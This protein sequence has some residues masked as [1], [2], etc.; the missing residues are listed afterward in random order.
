MRSRTSYGVSQAS[1]MGLAVGV[2]AG[3]A[4]GLLMAP[5]RGSDMRARL[6]DRA[7]DGS[8]RLQSLASSSRDWATHAIDRG[9]SLVEQGRRALRTSTPEPLRATVGEIASMHD[10]SQPSSYGVTS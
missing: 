9:L 8:A 6:R 7:S 10:G 2:T 5:T 4:V 3:L 1:L